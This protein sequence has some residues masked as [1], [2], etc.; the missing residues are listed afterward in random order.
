MQLLAA[1]LL[2][3]FKIVYYFHFYGRLFSLEGAPSQHYYTSQYYCFSF[4]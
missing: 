2:H 1:Y 3:D 4:F